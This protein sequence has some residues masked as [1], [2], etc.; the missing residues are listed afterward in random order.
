M[1]DV[2]SGMFLCRN[3]NARRFDGKEAFCKPV[4]IRVY[5]AP[6]P[7]RMRVV[8]YEMRFWP[9][10]EQPNSPERW[11]AHRAYQSPYCNQHSFSFTIGTLAIDQETLMTNIRRHFYS[12]VLN[13][14]ETRT[15]RD[16]FARLMDLNTGVWPGGTIEAPFQI[17]R[18]YHTWALDVAGDWSHTT[19]KE[20]IKYRGWR[21]DEE[22]PDYDGLYVQV[23]APYQ[24]SREL[25]SVARNHFADPEVQAKVRR[26]FGV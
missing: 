10:L 6:S 13:G 25:I 16:G 5:S 4:N 24:S 20:A 19:A 11:N 7:V 1:S 15:A 8:T 23:G 14:R 9:G 3:L 18:L 17:G 12:V 22:W 21:T 2:Y 26:K